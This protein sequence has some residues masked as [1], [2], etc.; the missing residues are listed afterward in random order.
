MGD[1][2]RWMSRPFRA[3]RFHGRNLG[4]CP[5]LEW[6]APVGLNRSEVAIKPLSFSKS[7]VSIRVHSWFKFGM[8]ME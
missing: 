8:R 7:S 5:R 6:A 4:R 3:F 1:A 2:A